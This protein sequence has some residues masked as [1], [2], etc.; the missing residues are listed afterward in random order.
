MRLGLAIQIA[1]FIVFI[2]LSI[3][4]DIDYHHCLVEEEKLADSFLFWIL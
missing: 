3:R 1:S 2:V 4:S